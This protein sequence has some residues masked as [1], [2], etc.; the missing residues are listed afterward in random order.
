M[1]DRIPVFCTLNCVVPDALAVKMSP[2]FVWLTIKA[3]LFPIPPDI[4]SGAGVVALPIN[5]LVSA[6]AERL[7]FPVPLGVRVRSPFVVVPIVAADPPPRLSVVESIERVA[8]ASI[9]ASTPAVIVVRPAA[10]SVVSEAAI[11]RESSPL[12]RVSPPVVV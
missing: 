2:L 11:V 8:A 1:N 3:A 10:E 5:T 9:V 6:S 7:M 4:D 12:S